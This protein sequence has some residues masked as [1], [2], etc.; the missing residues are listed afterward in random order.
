MFIK[1]QHLEKLHTD[2]T[3][4]IE[5]GTTHVFPKIDGT[6]GS[7][8]HDQGIQAGSRNR[9][10]TLDADNAGFYQA[11]SH[12]EAH[13]I[14]CAS[15]AHLIFYGEWLVPH[16]LKTYREDAWRKFYIFDVYNRSIDKYLPYNEYKP[17]LDKYEV[18]YIAPIA[19]IKNGNYET[20][21][22]CLSRNFFLIDDGK[23]NGEGIVIKNY[24]YQNKFG[25]QTWAKLITNAFKEEHH[26]EMGAPLVG[27][28]IIEDKIVSKFVDKHL[29][30]KVH[31]KITN[32]MDGWSSKYIPRLLHTV[33]YDLITEEMW[34]ILKDFKNPKIDFRT[35]NN[36][37]TQ[38][39]KELKP[40]VF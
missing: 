12:S 38:K 27:G 8:W 31:A 25:R 33:Y 14:L 5:I 40:E 15:N 1:Y 20:Y 18:D 30:D 28:E 21:Q 19:I 16:S 35:L 2:E 3:D 29:V 23:G 11:M 24:A 34:N 36:L 7:I 6:N 39:V 37:C 26:K 22:E 13:K 32:E 10:L 4:G 17:I 9:H